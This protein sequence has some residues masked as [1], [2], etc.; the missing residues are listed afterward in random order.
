MQV[1]TQITPEVIAPAIGLA[2]SW[3]IGIA[4]IIHMAKSS[5]LYDAGKK[6][7]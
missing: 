5:T 7:K 1:Q 6:G 3:L 2:M 4:V